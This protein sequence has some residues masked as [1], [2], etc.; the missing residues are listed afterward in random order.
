VRGDGRARPG[1]D[2]WGDGTVTASLT[3]DGS[4]TLTRYSSCRFTAGTD[5]WRRCKPF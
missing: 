5:G 3:M 2:L 1:D 4:V